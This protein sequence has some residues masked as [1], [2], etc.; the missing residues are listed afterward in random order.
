[1][2]AVY[3]TA[4]IRLIE[5]EAI[6]SGIAGIEMMNRAGL[7]A[8]KH[9][10]SHWPNIHKIA[11]LI[12][13]GNNG[14]DGLIL[15]KAAIEAG[16][17]C[18][19]YSE[20][21][22]SALKNE[23][24]LAFDATKSTLPKPKSLNDFEPERYELIVDALLGIGFNGTV[25]ERLHNTIE[26]I[27]AAETP[28]FAL[29]LPS[30]LNADRGIASPVAIQATKTMTF[31]GLKPGLVTGDGLQFC[32]E[33]VVEKLGLPSTLYHSITPPIHQATL[34]DFIS[35]I[36]PRKKNTHKNQEGHLLIIGG[37]AGMSGAV[38]I[39]ALGALYTG[40]GLVTVATHPAH[41]A[42]INLD[43]PEIMSHGIQK[44]KALTTLLDAANMILIGPGLGEDDWAK[45][46]W[47]YVI[48][49]NKRMVID[50]DA[51]NL[52]SESPQKNHD[53][54]LTP[55][56]GEAAKLLSQSTKDIQSQRWQTASSLHKKYGGVAVLKG[57]GTIISNGELDYVCGEGNPGMASA[58]MGDLLA[59]ITASLF[60]QGLNAF[61]AATTAVSLHARAA[62]HYA[63]EKGQR[64]LL[65][66]NL[67]DTLQALVN[68]QC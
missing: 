12:G 11:C 5:K 43:Q 56:P 61:D 45:S 41:A 58:G 31:I 48:K 2:K 55:H 49:Q 62:D 21:D 20:G 67:I 10:Q 22:L 59:G 68:Q 35:H 46:L 34:D 40:T 66:S 54:I 64:G 13:S 19:L 29:D 15:A 33:L 30:G 25:D 47:R 28:V 32:G 17:H 7:A 4:Q 37:N 60:A 24:K 8:F 3:T 9:L 23:A 27:N 51:L 44:P 39:A 18:D 50:A 52:L 38:K 42:L 16:L 63:V 57:A 6:K 14:G 1:M 36:K 26:T 53:W 65:A